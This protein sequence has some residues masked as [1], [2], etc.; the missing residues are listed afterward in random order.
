MPKS[1]ISEN[2][3][4]A[5]ADEAHRP[6]SSEVV[7]EMSVRIDFSFHLHTSTI[8]RL[9]KLPTLKL[10]VKRARGECHFKLSGGV[11]FWGLAGE[12]VFS[13]ELLSV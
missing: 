7:I 12:Q 4:C 9:V 8:L 6:R 2:Y 1:D 10:V 3:F 13:D 5:I 11:K